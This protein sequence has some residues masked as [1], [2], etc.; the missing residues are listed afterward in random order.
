MRGIKG[1]TRSLDYSSFATKQKLRS[2]VW[3]LRTSPIA[4][5]HESA[6]NAGTHSARMLKKLRLQAA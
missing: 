4:L 3:I 1:D 6:A 2:N 5:Q